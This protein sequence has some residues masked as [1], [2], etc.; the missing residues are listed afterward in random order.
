MGGIILCFES[1]L[2]HDRFTSVRHDS[3][4]VQKLNTRFH[5]AHLCHCIMKGLA[6]FFQHI[7]PFLET[8]YLW[9]A[10]FPIEALHR[11]GYLS[12]SGR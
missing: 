4:R 7:H 2:A 6:A 1:I 8:D 5:G 12:P 9:N 3:V 11:D 10:V